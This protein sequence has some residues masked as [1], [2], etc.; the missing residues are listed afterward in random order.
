M[1]DDECQIEVGQKWNTKK[2]EVIYCFSCNVAKLSSIFDLLAKQVRRIF[3][4]FL[5]HPLNSARP[6]SHPSNVWPSTRTQRCARSII[7]RCIFDW[8]RISLNMQTQSRN[9]SPPGPE[10]LR[11]YRHLNKNYIWK[12]LWGFL[13]SEKNWFSSNVF[14]GKKFSQKL[15]LCWS[16]ITKTLRTQHP[17]WS[18]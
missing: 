11:N 5:H 1:R 2:C 4:F 8:E 18:H 13:L 3:E 10:V 7:K 16:V 15:K 17:A 14:H 12:K 9:F 6:Q